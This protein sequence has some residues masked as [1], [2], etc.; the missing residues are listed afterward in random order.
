MIYVKYWH[1]GD[2]VHTRLQCC[3][4]FNIYAFLGGS[5]L[6]WFHLYQ[7]LASSL[8]Q[9]LLLGSFPINHIRLRAVLDTGD[10]IIR[11]PIKLK[12]P[13]PKFLHFKIWKK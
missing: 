11:L 12:R 10:K 8:T 6:P 2:E 4:L 9:G 7:I 5:V 3:T 13:W 1:A